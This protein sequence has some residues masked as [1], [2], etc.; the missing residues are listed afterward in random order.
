MRAGLV[1]PKDAVKIWDKVSPMLQRVV[2]QTEGELQPKDFLHNIVNKHMH[3]WIVIE[4]QN[5]VIVVITQII[6]YPNKK[7]LR[8]IALAGKNFKEAYNQFNSMIESFAIESGCSG[9]ELWGR[10]GWKKM[11]PEWKSNYIVFTKN[12]KERMD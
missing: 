9:L 8:I 7:I 1:S 6:N 4:K 3:L 2:D 10:K 11:L 12:L 5:I